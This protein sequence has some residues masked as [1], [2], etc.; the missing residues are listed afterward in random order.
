M[1]ETSFIPTLRNSQSSRGVRVQTNESS[2]MCKA[3]CRE[4][5]GLVHATQSNLERQC[6]WCLTWALTEGL[7]TCWTIMGKGTT[8]VKTQ[9]WKNSLG[10]LGNYNWKGYSE[11]QGWRGNQRSDKREV[12]CQ[13]SWVL[14]W[15]IDIFIIITA[16][17][18][19]HYI[20]F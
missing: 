19:S 6:W 14:Y 3:W 2:W 12:V 17:H 10:F 1:E 15:K 11:W 7:F 16:T 13:G 20:Y 4:K 8:C 18:H 9:R 5:E